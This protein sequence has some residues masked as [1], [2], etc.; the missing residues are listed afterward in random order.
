MSSEIKGQRGFHGTRIARWAGIVAM[1]ALAAVAIHFFTKDSSTTTKSDP[2]AGDKNEADKG[3]S[4]VSTDSAA[5]IVSLAPEMVRK[6]GIRIGTVQRRKLVSQITAP[7]RVAF[8]SEA[9]AVIGTPVQGR[10]VQ[11][12][13]RAG[14]H[15]KAGAMLAEIESA[16]L[17]EAQSEYLQR[18]AAVR[19]AQA[20]I[21][22]LTEIYE[23]VKKL[24][25]EN[26]LIGI[27][28][29]QQHELELKKAAGTLTTAQASLVAAENKLHLFGMNDDAISNLLKSG[30]AMPRYALR[31]PLAG[32]V[33]ERLINLG[34]LVKPEREKLFVVADTSIL[35]VWADVPENRASEVA[36]G[37]PARITLAPA[38]ET[39][40]AGSVS[41]V[42]PRIDD[43]TRSLGVR[44]EVKSDPAIRPGMFVQARIVGKSSADA[45][46]A[47]VS[48]PEA[49][50][51]MINGNAAVFLPASG[52]A[53]A[54]QPRLVSA[55]NYVDGMVAINS[56]LEEGER[57]VIVGSAILKAELLKSIAKDED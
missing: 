14:D 10:V 29:V 8:N 35:W 34:E 1:V 31:S 37:C 3:P 22:P 49:A 20:A 21:Q 32:E 27:N 51:Q 12:M 30:K 33:I 47:V 40:F 43:P 11:V 15:V 42:A 17:G 53:H 4:R 28:Q 6:Y 48:V 46:E 18:H 19:T 39:S 13:V 45:T 44:I 24:Y 7:A 2:R 38:G 5:Q 57:I 52:I 25:D 9:M 55:G 26:Q 56:G 50:I 41:Y 23:R 16:E 54:F 36:I